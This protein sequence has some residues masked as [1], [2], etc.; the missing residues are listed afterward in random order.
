MVGEKVI[1]RFIST[2]RGTK[3]L[4]TNCAIPGIIIAESERKRNELPK[5]WHKYRWQEMGRHW[6]VT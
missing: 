3:V 6:N 1:E 2:Q 4:L 5:M